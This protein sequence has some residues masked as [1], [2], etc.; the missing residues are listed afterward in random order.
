[1]LC[2]YLLENHSLPVVLYATECLILKVAQIK[3]IISWWN[4]VYREIF[5][6]NKW[7]SI[8]CLICSLNRLDVPRLIN[9]R[10]LSYIKRNSLMSISSTS[11]LNVLNKFMQCGDFVSIL[12][13]YNC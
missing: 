8:K 6:Y 4:S 7:E 3:E 11:F 5:G 2:R 1:M 10:F 9:L 13:K 12:N